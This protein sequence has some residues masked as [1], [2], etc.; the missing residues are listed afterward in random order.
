[1][2]CEEDAATSGCG[3]LRWMMEQRALK[4]EEDARTGVVQCKEHAGSGG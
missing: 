2:G 4:C 1:M 3:L